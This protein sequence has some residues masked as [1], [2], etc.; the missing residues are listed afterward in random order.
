L[1]IIGPIKICR[2]IHVGGADQFEWLEVLVIVIFGT[3]EHQMFEQVCETG[4]PAFLVFGANVI[5]DIDRDNRRF[6]VFVD[7]QAQ[8]VIERVFGKIDLDISGARIDG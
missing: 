8:S 3:V 1:K 7:N 4:F 6:V 5:P 2:A